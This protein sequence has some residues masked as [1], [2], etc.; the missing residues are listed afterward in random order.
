M[1]NAKK[2]VSFRL[3]LETRSKLNELATALGWTRNR[4]AENCIQTCHSHWR[5][6]NGNAAQADQQE[7]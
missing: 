6:L 4:V 1:S 2:V 3:D 5:D 7:P